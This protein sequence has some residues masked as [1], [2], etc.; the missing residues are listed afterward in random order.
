MKGKIDFI[1]GMLEDR[2]PFDITEAISHVGVGSENAIDDIIYQHEQ[3]VKREQQL[4][5]DLNKILLALLPENENQSDADIE[6]KD[7]GVLINGEETQ[8]TG[9]TKDVFEKLNNNKGE[10]LSF[11]E[12]DE[13][14]ETESHAEQP[15]KDAIKI[16]KKEIKP[17]ELKVKNKRGFGYKLTDK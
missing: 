5:G 1:W 7:W 6:I 15:L 11:K 12:L 13:Y 2:A 14:Q 8:I 17:F 16:I 3:D 4:K 9:K 10:Y